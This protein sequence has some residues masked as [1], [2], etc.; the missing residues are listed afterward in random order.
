MDLVQQANDLHDGK[1]QASAAEMIRQNTLVIGSKRAR[2]QAMREMEAIYDEVL[3]D[4]AAVEELVADEIDLRVEAANLSGEGLAI[5]REEV[6]LADM[7]M[8]MK[9][10][11]AQ[12][13]ISIEEYVQ[14]D[15]LNELA[16][17]EEEYRGFNEAF[18]EHVD[19]MLHGGIV[20]GQTIIATDNEIIRAAVEELDRDHAEL[21]ES[22]DRLIA[23]QQRGIEQAALAAIVMAE[24]DGY[25]DD[26]AEMLTDVEG[27]ISEEMA[28]AKAAGAASSTTVTIMLIAVALVSVLVGIVLGVVIAK[29]IV[30]PLAKGVQLSQS[31]AEG[32]LTATVEINQGDEVGMLA[33]AQ[34]NMIERLSDVVMNVK[35][36]TEY[37]SSGSE[38][39]STSAQEM[40]QGATEQASSAEEVSSSMEQMA[41]NIR[42]NADNAMQT[43]KIAI[44]AAQDAQ[45]SGDAVAESVG[46]MKQIADK[47]N[48]IEEI[49]RQTNLLALNAAI[50]AARAGEHGRGFAVVASEVRKLAERSQT[51][52]AEI[53]QLSSTTVE[54]SQ[55]AGEML[56]RL[57]PD[58]QKT[59]ELV[60]EISAASA[61]QNNGA[62]QINKAI[63]QLDTVVQQNAS[64]SEEVASTSE[65]LS[66]QS[67][68]LQ[69][70]MAFFKTHNQNNGKSGGKMLPAPGD[71]GS[72]GEKSGFA[73]SYKADR[74]SQTG[75]S[76][77]VAET[78]AKSA[79]EVPRLGEADDGKRDALDSDYEEY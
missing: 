5:L 7:A 37:V 38:E 13:R 59:A 41:S 55:R 1:F 39:L 73:A 3:I 46:A 42:Q 18:D 62:E 79:S 6:P 30:T 21:Q 60:Q 45:E 68:Q 71:K 77:A 32:D 24:L 20:E 51:S 49:A 58:I 63:L 11:V 44:K 27:L 72:R 28:A 8:E 31:L 76:T 70:A 25:G 64:A 15:D 23:A 33:D 26:A 29:G 19:A 75:S 43:E 22:A 14:T 74:P 16:H 54:V 10:E 2:L 34:R 50:E 65:E 56:G 40:S 17:I 66:S 53:S 61:E 9:S 67:I 78:S 36:A 57:V 35:A 48:I 52:A 4:S 12:T 47:I 69:E